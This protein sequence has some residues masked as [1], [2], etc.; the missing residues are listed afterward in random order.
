[1]A[2]DHP[3][4]DGGNDRVQAF[5]DFRKRMNERMLDEP[6]QVVRR[7]FALDTQT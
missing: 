4:S 3:V 7:L 1:M 6:H 5:T 2:H